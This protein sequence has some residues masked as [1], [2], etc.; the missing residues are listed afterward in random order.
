MIEVGIYVKNMEKLNLLLSNFEDNIKKIKEV[1]QNSIT[2]KKQFEV[3]SIY[4]GQEFCENLYPTKQ[5][6]LKAYNKVNGLGLTFVFITGII[7]ENQFDEIKEICYELI[8]KDNVRL[9][10][11]DPGLIS[12]FSESPINL[13]RLRNK[14]KRLNKMLDILNL[15]KESIQHL[16]SKSIYKTYNLKS[17]MFETDMVAQGTN[18]N[19]NLAIYFPYS[20]VTSMRDC[21]LCD[22]VCTKKCQTSWIK[23]GNSK[24]YQYGNTIFFNNKPFLNSYIDKIK[25]VIYQY[26]IPL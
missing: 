26:G 10:L 9:T 20:Y 22:K 8:T 19:E 18:T 7:R 16:E 24:L 13:G 15:Q 14:Q 2:S 3:S 6:V 12:E 4:F 1:L 23:L 11:N 25:R 21:P 5:E 17:T